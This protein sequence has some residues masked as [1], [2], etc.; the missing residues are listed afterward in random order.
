MNHKQDKQ[1]SRILEGTDLEEILDASPDELPELLGII[2]LPQ[3]SYI[4]QGG[5]QSW[6]GA[7]IGFGGELLPGAPLFTFTM[8]GAVIIQGQ[9]FPSASTIVWIL[10][11]GRH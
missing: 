8:S 5:W 7:S 10:L 3:S 9:M 2:S 4:T 1:F 6:R 11:K